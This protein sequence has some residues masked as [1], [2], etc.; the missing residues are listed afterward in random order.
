MDDVHRNIET[1]SAIRD[2]GVRI[3]VDDFGTGYSSLAYLSRLP[4]HILKIDRALITPMVDDPVATT[5][6]STIVTLAHS[7]HLEVVAE[8]VETDAQRTLLRSLRCDQL[9]GYLFSKPVPPDV[10]ARLVHANVAEV[11]AS[12][13][14]PDRT[15]IDGGL[16]LTRS[17][18]CRLRL[19]GR[20]AHDGRSSSGRVKPG[21][22]GRSRGSPSCA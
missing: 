3:A 7:L 8:G 15:G 20:D 11:A 2:L 9:Q 19:V 16:R 18:R 17:A 1:L 12:A 5:L 13:L 6:V 21:R 14:R 4:I 22:A 10:L